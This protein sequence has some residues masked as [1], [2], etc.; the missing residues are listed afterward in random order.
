MPTVAFSGSRDLPTSR[1]SVA[2]RFIEK[3]IAA[4]SPDTIVIHGDNGNVDWTVDAIA[5]ARGLTVQ[6]YPADWKRY[7][8]PGKKNPA[9][10]IRNAEMAKAKPDRWVFVWDGRSPGTR[11][12]KE[13][14]K[15]HGIPITE[16]I[17]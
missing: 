10:M 1:G 14:A 12:A 9:G 6:K 4:L 2:W 3:E 13:L 8:R 16:H 11:G 5:R 17:S 7:E 15:K